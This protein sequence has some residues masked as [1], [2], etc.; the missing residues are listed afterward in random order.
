MYSLGYQSFFVHVSGF[1]CRQPGSRVVVQHI[2]SHKIN[3]PDVVSEF[4]SVIV[5]LGAAVLDG[6]AETASARSSSLSQTAH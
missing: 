3:G 6:R 5:S 2:T 4:S 1:V